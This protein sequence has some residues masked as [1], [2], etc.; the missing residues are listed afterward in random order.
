GQYLAGVSE[1]KPLPGY[2]EEKGV[3]PDST[4]PTYVA[5]RLMIQNW[6][7]AGVPF[8]LRTGKRMPERVSEIAIQYQEIPHALF[9]GQDGKA[10]HRPNVLMLRIQPDEGIALRFATKVPG[11][12]MRL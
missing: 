10:A 11:E 3:A 9:R 12:A 1:G 4:T 8:Y 5:L 6:R 7:W 2:R